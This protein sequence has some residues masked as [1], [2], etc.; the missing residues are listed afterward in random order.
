MDEYWR[1]WNIPTHTWLMKHIQVPLVRAGMSRLMA[2][3]C[4][5]FVSAVFHELLVSVPVHTSFV[6]FYWNDG[7]YP[8]NHPHKKA[9]PGKPN[10][11]RNFLAQFL[12]PW[13]TP[14]DSFVLQ[15]LLK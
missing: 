5:F 7:Q 4:V 13:P 12:F 10:R 15:R 11:E 14:R 1:I 2:G 3:V 8:I 9:V 6:G